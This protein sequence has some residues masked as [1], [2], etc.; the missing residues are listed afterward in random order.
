MVLAVLVVLLPVGWV[1][2]MFLNLFH[3]HEHCMKG[4]GL[5][6]SQFALEH[7]GKYPFHTNGFGDALIVLLKE[8]PDD[9]RLFTAPGDDGSLLKKYLKT[10]GDV[11]EERCTRAY[12]QGLSESNN[13]DIALLFDRYPTRG[14]DHFRRPWGP[15]LREVWLLGGGHSILNESAWPEFARKQIELLVAEG[16]PRSEAE[17]YFLPPEQ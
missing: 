16:I 5:S 10:E 9:P 3:A 2:A 4:A 1:T 11:P 7:K 15:P 14:G 12:V 13:P 8:L 6:L 17:K